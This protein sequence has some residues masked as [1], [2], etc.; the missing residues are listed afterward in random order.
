MSL[1]GAL[2]ACRIAF[3]EPDVLAVERRVPAAL[4]A[5]LRARGHAI[6]DVDGIGNAHALE[7]EYGADGAIVGLVG[8]AD[9]RGAGAAATW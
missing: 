4:R 7:L 1:D 3:V 9:H 6:R 2:A 5:A 8:A